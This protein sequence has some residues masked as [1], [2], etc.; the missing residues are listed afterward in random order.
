M[1]DQAKKMP[2]KS[3]ET[4]VADWFT[5]LRITGLCCVEYAQ[6]PQSAFNKHEY[7]LGKHAVKAFIPTYMKFYNNKGDLIHIHTIKGNL[8]EFPKKLKVTFLIQ[9]NRQNVR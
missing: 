1:L 2:T 5:F 6:K 4:V 7:P 9:K 8:Q 3:R